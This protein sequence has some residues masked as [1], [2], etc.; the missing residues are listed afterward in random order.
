MQA[1][2]KNDI[3]NGN[4]GC[5]YRIVRASSPTTGWVLNLSEA[6]SWPVERDFGVLRSHS[7]VNGQSTNC[8][9]LPD[10]A[11]YSDKAR[12]RANAAYEAIKPLLFSADGTE[13]ADI[14][15]ES[16]RNQLVR[17]RA[18]ELGIS[19]TTVYGYLKKW[20]SLGQ[21]R[22]ALIPGSSINGK[23]QKPGTAGRGRKPEDG[24]YSVFQM[25]DADINIAK[26]FLE[27]RY[28]KKEHASLSDVYIELLKKHY[29]FRDGNGANVL[30]PS[31]EHPS[32]HQFR[33][34][35]NKYFSREEIK[36]G[37][38]GDK[39][40]EREHNPMVGSALEEAVAPGHIYEIDATIL[41]VFLVAVANRE[42]II[43]KPTLYLIYDRKTRLC[44]GFHLSLENASWIGAMQAILSIAADKRTLCEKYGQPYDPAHWP[45]DGIFPAKFLGDRGEMASRNSDRICDGMQ[46]TISNT[47][48]LLPIRK[49]LV[50]SGF[51]VIHRA[52]MNDAPGY[53]PPREAK[54][55]R[56]KK[57][58]LD[59][60]LTLDECTSLIL[61]AII[62]HN[63]TVMR[64]YPLSPDK[65]LA[66]W[67]AVP[68]QLW[69]NE[70]VQHG[71]A[72]A[73]YTHDYLHLQLL[74]RAADDKK[75]LVTQDGIKFRNCTYK[76]DDNKTVRNWIVTAGLKGSFELNCSYDP[77]LVDHIIVYGTDG[78]PHK[79]E[80]AEDSDRFTGYS[81]A[82]LEFVLA[83]ERRNKKLLEDATKQATA[84]RKEV[85]EMIVKAAKT[86]T[87]QALTG[88]ARSARK[89]DNAPARDFEMTNRRHDEVNMPPTGDG[90]RIGGNVIPL[91]SSNLVGGN[92][93]QQPRT[94]LDAAAERPRSAIDDLLRRKAQEKTNELAHL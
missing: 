35:L 31:G 76:C 9:K 29:A 12:N 6:H 48:A 66:G 67:N 84:E 60:A 28:I 80:L 42:K 62:K 94:T 16:K 2:L 87:K 70:T 85:A 37:K 57:Y 51:A 71:C 90:A 11:F 23:N 32:I 18:D 81:F 8:A 19:K 50:E 24:R 17:A 58:H 65:V 5:Q 86:A 43:G 27:K 63:T 82:E 30:R 44:V 33:N 15:D 55:R 93:H 77:R 39:N 68:T 49:G 26:Q 89:K 83:V 10:F 3:F 61:G 88:A 40:F 14:L 41:D 38:V 92:A 25:G 21:S 53:E 78:K 74:P 7:Q 46:A 59:A 1:L 20:W 75:P 91:P 72:G 56:A 13:N 52:I 22:Y 79:C 34:V 36:R 47:Q 45:A 4:D 69:R 64:R 73:R 54:K